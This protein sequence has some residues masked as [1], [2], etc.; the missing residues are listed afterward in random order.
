MNWYKKAQQE[1]F[2]FLENMPIQQK[3]N[4]E[5]SEEYQ[6]LF[7]NAN[8][9]LEEDLEYNAHN[10]NELANILNRHKVEW[11]KINFPKADP[12]IRLEYQ[13]KPYII[14]DFESPQLEDPREWIYDIYDYHLDE[15]IPSQDFNE[16]FWNGVTKGSTVYHA[17]TEENKDSILKEGLR[18]EDRTRG[19]NNR[20]TGNAIF[21]SDN[22]D[23]ISSYGDVVFEINLG[24]MKADGYMPQVSQEGPLESA[25]QRNSLAY[26][27]GIDN[28]DFSSEYEGEGIYPT[29]VVFF[30]NIPAKYLRLL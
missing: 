25:E 17:T 16:D 8:I 2:G 4:I 24:Q 19:I 9:D 21:T 6:K 14:T 7:D 22:P 18:L 23:D 20:Y 3:P 28:I 30:D 27:I 13:K 5:D 10:Y 11:E 29:T 12:I 15:Y 26:L 1:Q